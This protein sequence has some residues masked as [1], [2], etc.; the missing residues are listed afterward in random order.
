MNKSVNKT[1]SKKDKRFK[2]HAVHIKQ[3]FYVIEKET[4][5]GH[6]PESLFDYPIFSQRTLSQEA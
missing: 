1:Q 4:S 6:I 5:H 3:Y 2:I